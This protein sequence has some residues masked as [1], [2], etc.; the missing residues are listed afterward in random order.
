MFAQTL[1]PVAWLL[2]LAATPVMSQESTATDEPVVAN[3]PVLARTPV[4]YRAQRL[5]GAFD[6]EETDDAGVPLGLTQPMPRNW[7][8][9]GRNPDTADPNFLAQPLHQHLIQ[10]PDYPRYTNAGYQS[11]RELRAGNGINPDDAALRVPDNVLP[12]LTPPDAN[13]EEPDADREPARPANMPARYEPTPSGNFCL[14]LALDSGQV[15]VFNEVGTLGANPGSDYRIETVVRTEGLHTAFAR[16][17]AFFVDDQGRMIESTQVQ[18]SPLRTDGRWQH[19]RLDLWSPA[20][21][22]ALPG[23]PAWIGLKLELLQSHADRKSVLGVHQVVPTEVRG[24]AYFDDVSI[25]V[26]PQVTVRT[27]SSVNVISDPAKPEL[28]MAVRDIVGEGLIAVARLEDHRGA[29]VARDTRPSGAGAPRTWTWNPDLSRAPYGPYICVLEVRQPSPDGSGPGPIIGSDRTTIFWTPDPRRTPGAEAG[30]DALRRFDLVATEADDI[31]L[32]LIVELARALNFGSV[33]LSLWGPD[34]DATRPEARIAQLQNVLQP[35]W[36]QGR[37]VGLSLWPTPEGLS[38]AAELANAANESAGTSGALI[39]ARTNASAGPPSEDLMVRLANEDPAL[40]AALRPYFRAMGQRVA[41]WPIGPYAGGSSFNEAEAIRAA[42]ALRQLTPRPTA[43]RPVHLADWPADG[44]NP[45]AEAVQPIAV[46]PQAVMPDDLEAYLGDIAPGRQGS[47]D[48]AGPA[49]HLEPLAAGTSAHEDR[50][51]DLAIRMLEAWRIGAERLS[52]PALMNV[53][54]HGGARLEPD[55]LL[56]AYVNTA[57]HLAGRR[58]VG[59]LQPQTGTRGI[60]LDGPNGGCLAI[61][62]ERAGPGAEPIAMRL[63]EEQSIAYDVWGNAWRLPA[64]MGRPGAPTG[65]SELPRSRTPIF[66][67]NIDVKLMLFRAGFELDDPFIPASQSRH[68]RRVRLVNPWSVTITGYVT[69]RPPENWST[70]PARQTFSIQPGESFEFDVAITVPPS[71]TAGIKTLIADVNLQA[72]E[73]MD[74]RLQAPMELGLDGVE[75]DASL[76]LQPS[77]SDGPEAKPDAVV[78]LTITNTNKTPTAFRAFASLYGFAREERFVPEIAPGRTV[79][80]R[81][82]FPGGS[83]NLDEHAIRTG[84]RRVRPPATLNIRL[85]LGDLR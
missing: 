32:P 72:S 74:L 3:Q 27:A 49:I 65:R 28:R 38:A 42:R 1:L 79:T 37:S 54:P 45:A 56:L 68:L 82:V 77:T 59:V 41:A 81:F 57:G 84:V 50:A 17:T 76:T 24:A 29:I 6:F 2:G 44:L 20:E 69:L 53:R 55:P 16:V 80:R 10:M 48:N 64:S 63:G 43:W 31:A 8:I 75:V 22:Q 40:L 85:T 73:P 70:S 15:G 33:T 52:M 35:L 78:T 46:V 23:R 11:H 30:L 39:S 83:A 36:A 71:E 7:Y 58:V 62:D 47:A 13:E 18:S 12:P 9:I 4:A 19:V 61:W 66:I 34:T 51:A 5:V 26:L 14:M 67:E 25:W 60:I 21:L